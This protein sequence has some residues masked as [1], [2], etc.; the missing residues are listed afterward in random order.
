MSVKI[1]FYRGPPRRWWHKLSHLLIC[2]FTTSA[3]SHCELVID[4]VCWSSSARD[5]GV[6]QKVIDLNDGK[7][8]VF[9]VPEAV[10]P[11][12]ALQWFLARE[13]KSYDYMGVVRFLL[14]FVRQ[15][16]DKWFCSEAVAESLGLPCATK[17]TPQDLYEW[18]CDAN[19]RTRNAASSD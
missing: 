15:G 9:D 4:G 2:F 19:N 12:S 1:A 6:R 17:T 13:G 10:D 5:G 8:I 14:P 18:I 16:R 11:I 7:W 3:Y